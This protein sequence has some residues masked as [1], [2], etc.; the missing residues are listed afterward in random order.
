MLKRP[1]VDVEGIK[2][3]AQLRYKDEIAKGLFTDET[4]K[5]MEDLAERLI[6]EE[7][8]RIYSMKNPAIF[9]WIVHEMKH[10]GRETLFKFFV[11]K[12]AANYFLEAWKEL[13]KMLF[14]MDFIPWFSS[15]SEQKKVLTEIVEKFA[16]ENKDRV[17]FVD[18]E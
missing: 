16:G 6:T 1:V 8:A 7:Q 17:S 10:K 12:K 15:K 5:E 13:E 11:N 14:S 9:V 4:K 2:Q 3:Q 18:V